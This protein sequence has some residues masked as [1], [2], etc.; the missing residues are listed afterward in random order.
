[1]AEQTFLSLKLGDM[2]GLANGARRRIV[3]RAPG[4]DQGLAAALAKASRRLGED[5]VTVLLDVAEDNCRVG[6]GECEGYSILVEGAVAVRACPGLRIGFL[7]IDDDGYVELRFW[8]DPGATPSEITSAVTRAI[9]VIAAN[10]Q[11]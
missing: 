3:F 2:G 1:M 5:R 6:Y 11:A 9:T 7:L 10:L 4:L 8:T